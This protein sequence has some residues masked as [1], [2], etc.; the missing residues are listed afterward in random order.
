MSSNSIFSNFIH[1][2]VEEADLL[3]APL[4]VG[5]A[6]DTALSRRCDDLARAATRLGL[7]A[8]HDPLVLLKASFSAPKHMHTSYF[9]FLPS[10]FSYMEQMLMLMLTNPSD[11]PDPPSF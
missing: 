4:T 7:I 5:T 10:H 8:A 2:N 9:S 3:G 11:I 6:M 1:L